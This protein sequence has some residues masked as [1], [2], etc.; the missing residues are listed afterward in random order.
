MAGIVPNAPATRK[1]LIFAHRIRKTFVN[2]SIRQVR[3]FIAAAEAGQ[4]AAAAAKVHV[5]QAAIASSIRQLEQ[6]L[7]LELFTRH[8]ASGVSLTVD[9]HR[10]L[11]HAHQI[12]GAVHAALRDPD[13]AQRE[14][15]GKLRVV[16]SHS[17][18]GSYVVPAIARFV[19]AYPAVDLDLVEMVR[20]RA[21]QALRDGRADAGLLWLDNVQGHAGL[22]ALALTR[23]RRQLWLPAAH[24]LLE[25]RGIALRDL[26]G[27]PYGLFSMDETPRS[28]LRFMRAAGVEPQVRYRV[29][30]LEAL[31]SLVAQGLAV[32]VLADVAY[33]PFSSEGLRI[34]ARP[35]TDAI[36]PIEIGLVR[37]TEAESNSALR[38]FAQF[39]QLSFGGGS[40]G[41]RGA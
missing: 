5:T 14:V 31:R 1:R 40:V 12:V 27:L 36:P 3:Y 26:A 20:P 28:T 21:E 38:E 37:H 13:L 24:P 41:A 16:A 23:S 15:V 30:S 4:F 32:T 19:K 18:L 29:T 22:E 17:I 9:G 34:E 33:R 39:M 25:R 8:H 7:G 11:Q 10:F 2:F 6:A 35:L